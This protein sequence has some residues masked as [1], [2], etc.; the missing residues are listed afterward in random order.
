MKLSEDAVV[1]LAQR[2]F[3][4]LR[5]KAVHAGRA[6]AR[7]QRFRYE[8]P[9]EVRRGWDELAPAER[10]HWRRAVADYA[11]VFLAA[12]WLPPLADRKRQAPRREGANRSARFRI[13]KGE[14]SLPQRSGRR[15]SKQRGG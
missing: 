11:E 12:G 2:A 6:Y 1:G 14:R 10:Q 13:S 15:N 4:H 3:L 8:E 7:R 5:A 9:D